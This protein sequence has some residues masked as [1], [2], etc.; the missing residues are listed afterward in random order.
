MDISK[1]MV[2]KMDILEE[3]KILL[4]R[5][6]EH[7]VEVKSEDDIKHYDDGVRNAMNALDSLITINFD[8]EKDRLIY[9]KYKEQSNFVRY[10]RLTD[11]LQQLEESGQIHLAK[12]S[13]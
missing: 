3:M 7:A 9:Q 10:M 1:V 6:R 13:D 11:V 2:E 12:E 8:S 5:M 4:S